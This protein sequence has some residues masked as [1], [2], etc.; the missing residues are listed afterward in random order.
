VQEAMKLLDSQ[1]LKRI[2]R[3]VPIDRTK[4]PPE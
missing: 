2:P 3:P 1:A 4:R